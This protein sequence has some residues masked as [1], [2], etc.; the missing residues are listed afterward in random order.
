[1]QPEITWPEILRRARPRIVAHR[2]YSGRA[3]ENTLPAFEAAVAAG[4]D[5]V[6]FDVEGTQDGVAVVIHDETVDRTTDGRGAVA[7]LDAA[8]LAGLDAG[9]SFGPAFAGTRIPTLAEVLGALAGRIAVNVEIKA[10]AD[11]AVVTRVLAAAGLGAQALV[12]SFDVDLLRRVRARDGSVPLAVAVDRVSSPEAILDL[13]RELGLLF[14]A[15]DADLLED[16]ELRALQAA[17]LPVLPWTIDDAPAMRRWLAAGVRGF[18]T[19]EIDVALG[20]VGR[21]AET[22]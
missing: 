18:F 7:D 20:V 8:D 21:T 22:S 5:A 15:P 19:N 2:G 3:P 17:G 16:G 14:V 13:A 6:E 12:S 1:M 9:S 11:P 4:A 10:G